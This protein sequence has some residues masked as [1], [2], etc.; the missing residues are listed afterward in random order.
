ML[1]NWSLQLFSQNCDQAP[2]STYVLCT[3]FIY[4]CGDLQFK[5]DSERRFLRNFSSQIYLFLEFLA[6][7]CR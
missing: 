6:E 2:H 5:V 3:N 1:H 7:I 4:D